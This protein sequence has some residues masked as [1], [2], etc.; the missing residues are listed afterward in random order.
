MVA[1]DRRSARLAVHFLVLLG[2]VQQLLEAFFDNVPLGGLPPKSS[3]DES[4]PPAKRFVAW[5]CSPLLESTPNNSR[6]RS[7]AGDSIE[8]RHG[9]G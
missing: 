2:V 1:Q 8:C 7:S 5:F 4:A 3:S 6:T 9:V